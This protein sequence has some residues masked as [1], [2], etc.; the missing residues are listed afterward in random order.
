MQ[1][2]PPRRHPEAALWE[3]SASGR[4]GESG[5]PELRK[6]AHRASLNEAHVWLWWGPSGRRWEDGQAQRAESQAVGSRL[7][8]GGICS[9]RRCLK[10]V[11]RSERASGSQSPC[12]VIRTWGE[13]GPGRRGKSQLVRVRRRK[14][15][16][17]GKPYS[18]IHGFWHFESIPT[19]PW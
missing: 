16:M 17:E 4:D 10:R 8:T 19:T 12:G 5:G 7:H 15:M 6:R 2:G 13:R 1:A 18:G 14:M 11:I 3:R 9:S